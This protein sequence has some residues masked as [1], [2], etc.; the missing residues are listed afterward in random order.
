M[1]AVDINEKVWSAVGGRLLRNSTE[2]CSA[3]KLEVKDRPQR[4]AREN[5]HPIHTPPCT[6]ACTCPQRHACPWSHVGTQLYA[7]SCTAGMI[8]CTILYMHDHDVQSWHVY[9]YMHK[10]SVCTITTYKH[11]PKHRIT[12]VHR[13]VYTHTHIHMHVHYHA[14]GRAITYP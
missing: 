5:G 10:H 13:T 1:H 3:K 12:C 4:Q 8:T 7:Q 9:N 2:G 11:R 14:Q 6:Q